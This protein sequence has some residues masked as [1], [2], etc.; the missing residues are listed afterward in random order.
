[1]R[2]RTAFAVAVISG[3]AWLGVPTSA[4]ADELPPAP[5]ETSEVTAAAEDPVSEP[6]PDP[7][8]VPTSEVTE[9]E[10]EDTAAPTE[11]PAETS[12]EETASSA[13]G[14]TGDPTD[15]P[16]DAQPAET[17]D[18]T[19]AAEEGEAT[20]PTDSAATDEEQEAATIEV[21]QAAAE[22]GRDPR[23]S[24]GDVNCTNMTV[25]VRLDNSQ[26]T[27]V[28]VHEV[29]AG[30]ADGDDWPSFFFDVAVS[31]GAIEIVHVPVTEDTED[32]ILVAGDT[33]AIAPLGSILASA[34]L[35]IDCT[36]DDDPHDPQARIGSLDCAQRTVD[37][38]LDN[39][40]SEDETIYLV[41][42]ISSANEEPGYEQ[43][44]NLPAG[45]VQTVLVPVTENS[46]VRVAVGDE[47][48]LDE[49]EGENGYLALEVFPVD[50]TPGDE[51]RA[52]IGQVDCTSL[53]VP[54]TLDNT[55]SPVET[56]FVILTE[57]SEDGEPTYDESFDVAA[58]A[59]GFV[60]VPVPDNAG[61]MVDVAPEDSADFFGRSAT[62]ALEGFE[63]DCGRAPAGRALPRL[64]VGAGALA[65]TG[66]TGLTLPI[67][68]LTLLTSGGVLT[69]L[70]RRR[71]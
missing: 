59:K 51:P 63:V 38:T 32:E 35:T 54:V 61:V 48:V 56:T 71:S 66:A 25:P 8:D 29:L 16:E 70:G 52:G 46:A 11:E 47:E 12:A 10:P 1:M 64:A 3:L 69:L 58:G 4:A 17:T 65:A 68:G 22:D 9:P 5:A 44:F 34:V 6:T 18:V 33:G 23:A 60:A 53:T 41:G 62:Y 45:D 67:A 30:E 40:R 13:E 55:R 57:D 27:E 39:S 26:S 21:A 20:G 31:A 15:A 19:P 43:T 36:D 28:V 50:C 42:A 37:V 14:A 49:T 24:I 2:I 7:T